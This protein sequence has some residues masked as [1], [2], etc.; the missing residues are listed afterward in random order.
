[1]FPLSVSNALGKMRKAEINIQTNSWR[2][3]L[4][5]YERASSENLKINHTN[6]D[7]PY[8]VPGMLKS[9]ATFSL[10]M[11]D[12]VAINVN[13]NYHSEEVFLRLLKVYRQFLNKGLE[14]DV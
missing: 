5:F 14:L 6:K 11:M 4:N 12:R 10:I 8:T 3:I 7:F 9:Y 1:M 2:R 13:I